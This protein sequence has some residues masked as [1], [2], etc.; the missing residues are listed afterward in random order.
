MIDDLDRAGNNERPYRQHAEGGGGDG[1]PY[2]GQF[3]AIFYGRAIFG[4]DVPAR[5]QLIA[6]NRSIDEI[7]QIIGG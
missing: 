1:S 5:E 6:C 7:R 4:T 3:A 2:E